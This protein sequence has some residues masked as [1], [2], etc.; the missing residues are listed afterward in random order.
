MLEANW[1]EFS[2]ASVPEAQ[3]LRRWNEFG[4]DTLC[5]MVVDPVDR[6]SFNASLKRIDVGSMGLVFMETSPATALS[7]ATQI[8]NWASPDRDALVLT[9]VDHGGCNLSQDKWDL[10]LAAGDMVIRDLAR[11]WRNLSA[12][13]SGLILVK[14][15]FTTVLKNVSD[16]ERIIGRRLSGRLPPVALAASVIRAS[17]HA[18]LTD[19]DGEWY[20]LLGDILSDVFRLVCDGTELREDLGKS[21][22]AY[23][24]RR[25]AVAYIL[26]HLNDPELSVTQ[27]A[28]NI[29]V[30]MRQLQR[31]FASCGK[32]PRQFILDQRLELAAKKILGSSDNG[33]ARITDIA[34]DTGFNDVS[35]FSRAFSRRFGC[36]P[37][38]YRSLHRH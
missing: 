22:I 33:Q 11:P 23:T 9:V 17:R 24:V 14:V 36:A 31:S 2:T 13:T 25:D 8:G 12:Q 10:D 29:G 20:D 4:S 26:H 3:R 21:S 15:P 37:R 35:H 27:V 34:F 5:E 1:Q 28:D 32:T 38:V 18:L 6:S 16:P 19:P 30:S 7:S